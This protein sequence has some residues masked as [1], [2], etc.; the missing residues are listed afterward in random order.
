MTGKRFVTI[1]EYPG[2][3]LVEASKCAGAEQGALDVWTMLREIGPGE[4]GFGNEGYDVPFS[5]FG[6]YLCGRVAMKLGRNLRPGRVPMTT[7]WLYD[8]HTPVAVSKL[9]HRLNE[10]LR[11]VGGHIGYCVRPSKRGKGYG[12]GLLALT[13]V[14]AQE[15]GLALVLITCNADN[16]ASRRIVEHNGGTL[17][18]MAEGVCYYW[19]STEIRRTRAS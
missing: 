6:D 16:T 15:L 2:L 4:N 9:R 13:L 17:S 12:T 7:F 10:S 14:A 11:R 18:G 1:A 8:G 19:V 5:R 3:R